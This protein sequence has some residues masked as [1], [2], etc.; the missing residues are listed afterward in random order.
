[1][2]ASGSN[3]RKGVQDDD[4]VDPPTSQSSTPSSTRLANIPKEAVEEAADFLRR[5]V[6]FKD[7]DDKILKSLKYVWFNVQGALEND[8]EL[9]KRLASKE[10]FHANVT[11][12]G[13][14]TFIDTLRTM[15][16]NSDTQGSKAWEYLF[17][18]GTSF[19][20]VQAF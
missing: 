12:K 2:M 10:E 14:K 8:P 18:D 20:L 5:N 3:S 13:E 17:E 11:K 9:K 16:A 7:D 4:R 19:A 6:L 1:M 15:A